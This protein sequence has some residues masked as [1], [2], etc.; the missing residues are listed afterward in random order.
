MLVTGQD[1]ELAA[2]QRIVAGTQAM[3][4]YKPLKML[5]QQRRRGGGEAWPRA[6]PIIAPQTANN[7]DDRCPHRFC[8]DMV[9]VT[10][11]NMIDTVIKDGL[12]PYDDVYRGVPEAQRPARAE[13]AAK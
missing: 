5:A 4:I 11:E 3:T 1:A 2:C 12:H 7:G 9:T 13:L 10:K 6:K 8:S